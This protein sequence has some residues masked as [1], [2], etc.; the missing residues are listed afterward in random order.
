[1]AGRTCWQRRQRT[2]VGA[3]PMETRAM[4]TEHVR[5]GSVSP[6]H[7]RHRCTTRT[8]AMHA[9]HPAWVAQLAPIA[10]ARGGGQAE[11]HSD[12]RAA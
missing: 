6:W 2:A 4:H 12:V 8:W 7:P 3:T 9:P 1:V 10:A 11:R 5:H